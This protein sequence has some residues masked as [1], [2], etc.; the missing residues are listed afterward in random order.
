MPVDSDRK[1]EIAGT[2]DRNE[3]PLNQNPPQKIEEDLN[4][5]W[6][7]HHTHHHKSIYYK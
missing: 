5:R 1:N 3:L 2:S 7:I 4:L 6:V